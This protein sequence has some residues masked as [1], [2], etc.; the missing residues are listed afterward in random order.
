MG[1]HDYVRVVCLWLC[2]EGER[3]MRFEGAGAIIYT[4]FGGRL[5]MIH[6]LVV[7]WLLVVS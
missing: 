6:F 1:T 3:E 2:V 4:L 5:R 7:T